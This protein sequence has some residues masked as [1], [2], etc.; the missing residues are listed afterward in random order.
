MAVR[1]SGADLVLGAVPGWGAG[2]GRAGAR[3][4]WAVHRQGA[5]RRVRA[6]GHRRA[7][8]PP[9]GDWRGAGAPTSGVIPAA[10]R[11]QQTNCRVQPTAETL[12]I[13]TTGGRITNGRTVLRRTLNVSRLDAQCARVPTKIFLNT[14]PTTLVI[15]GP[16]NSDLRPASFVCFHQK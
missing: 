14:I 15:H 2:R 16:R 1:C 13:N 6:G 9:R 7:A 12:N 5:G 10:R 3:P 11:L 4:H 8:A